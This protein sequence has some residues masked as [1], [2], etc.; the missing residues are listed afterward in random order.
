MGGSQ[1]DLGWVRNKREMALCKW[2]ISN[3]DTLV[4]SYKSKSLVNASEYQRLLISDDL[5]DLS[6]VSEMLEGFYFFKIHEAEIYLSY[7][8]EY[9]NQIIDVGDFDWLKYNDDACYFCWI[10][11]RTIGEPDL[12]M[13]NV[14]EKM[15]SMLM[16]KVNSFHSFIK[17]QPSFCYKTL[18]LPEFP[19]N[20]KERLRAIKNYFD[21]VPLTKHD[22]SNLLKIIRSSWHDIHRGKT[23]LALDKKNKLLCEWAWQYL[24]KAP[25]KNKNNPVTT[26]SI[27]INP[28]YQLLPLIQP[29]ITQEYFFA[30]RA[31]WLFLY[32]GKSEEASF[33]KK[34]HRAKE[35]YLYRAKKRKPKRKNKESKKKAKTKVHP[36]L[37]LSGSTA[38]ADNKPEGV[39]KAPFKASQE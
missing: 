24:G 13:L 37:D 10:A 33:L 18:D 12:A 36:Y 6:V 2:L 5:D 7:V 20:T 22:K 31:V 8:K 11:L 39:S 1:R 35:T 38:G 29:Q 16:I 9:I 32:K 28:I 27:I 4:E 17:P 25:R 3:D 30:I 34:F 26:A 23:R 15:S 14:K 19:V 21:R